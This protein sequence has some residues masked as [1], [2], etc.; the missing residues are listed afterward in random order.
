[1]AAVAAAQ[2]Q[3][4]VPQDAAFED[5]VELVLDELR[6]LGPDRRLCPGDEARGLLLRKLVQRGRAGRGRADWSERSDMEAP[7]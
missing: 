3:E 5:D 2:S 4:A 7:S 6:Q 1:M